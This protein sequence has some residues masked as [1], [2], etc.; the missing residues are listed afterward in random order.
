MQIRLAHLDDAD[1][2][3]CLSRAEIEHGL[4]WRWTPE[5][6]R[7]SMRDADTNVVVAVNGSRLLGFGIMVYR[8]E[9]AHLCLLAVQPG[10]R[11]QGVGAAL[12][13]WLEQVA[14]V[15]GI[16]RFGLEARQDNLAALAFYRRQG[17]R[18]VA[19]VAGMYQGVEAGVRL[20]KELT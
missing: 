1:A 10:H 16:T 9:R 11:R 17:Y 6:V 15:A 18:R 7:R 12:L 4:D 2:V 8:D 20:Q 13:A 14:Q 3:A 19:V 5:R